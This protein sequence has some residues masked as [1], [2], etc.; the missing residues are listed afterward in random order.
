MKSSA[1][2]A[3]LERDIRAFEEW[4]RS[5]M[6]TLGELEQEIPLIPTVKQ[7]LFGKQGRNGSWPR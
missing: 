5:A 7:S 3:D 1:T 6:P 2:T 4:Q